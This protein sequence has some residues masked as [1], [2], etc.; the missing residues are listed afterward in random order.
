M[1]GLVLGQ[2]QTKGQLLDLAKHVKWDPF[3]KGGKYKDLPFVASKAR[4]A[5]A[6]DFMA[7][8]MPTSSF[9]L[10]CEQ[11]L[12]L[13]AKGKASKHKLL[14][15]QTMHRLLACSEKCVSGRRFL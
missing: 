11:Y 1:R 3:K 6:Q 14:V 10:R 12:R 9:G 7:S 4:Q 15:S 2:R 8:A 13:K 5:E